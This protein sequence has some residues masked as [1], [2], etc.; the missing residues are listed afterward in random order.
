MS[1]ANIPTTD[2]VSLAQWYHLDD[3]AH[4]VHFYAEDA[5][6]LDGL[7]R[8]VGT[9]LGAG[10]AAIVIATKEHRDGLAQR[11]RARGIDPDRAAEQGRYVVLD[12]AET[13]S[14]IMV[15]GWPDAKR[16][17]EVV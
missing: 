3:R 14:K 5:F 13:L 9:A 16:F 4:A 2:A 15:D 6:L 12:A 8:F 7:S 10:D 17:A 11:L 1:T